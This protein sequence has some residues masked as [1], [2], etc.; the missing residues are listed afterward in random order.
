M[1]TLLAID[2]ETSVN[3]KADWRVWRKGFQVDSVAISWRGPSGSFQSR[4]FDDQTE[5]R[6]LI[7]KL[8][9]AQTPLVVHNL[10]FE[11]AVTQKCFGLPLNFVADTMRLAKLR[12]GG[13]DWRD[14]TF[15]SEEDRLDL[16]LEESHK[17]TGLSLEACA[18]RFLPAEYHNHKQEAHQWLETHAGIK[19]KHGGHLHLLPKDIL[20]R[21]NTADT[22]ITLRLHE[23]LTE[24][25]E[26]V[27]Y[28]W[29]QDWENYT[30][31][32]QWHIDAYLRGLQVDRAGLAQTIIDLEAEIEAVEQSFRAEA[33]EALVAF[34]KARGEPF[35]VGSNKQLKE[36]L[37]D[38]LGIVPTKCTAKGEEAIENGMKP[39]DAC[40]QYPSFASKHLATYGKLGEIL[41]K[42]RKTLLVLQQTCGAYLQSEEDGLGHPDVR[43][44]GTKTNRVS[45][46]YQ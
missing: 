30:A 17:R 42:R 1:G 26:T 34:E 29:G 19:T 2:Y 15:M 20:A 22:E 18:S 36:L 39:E 27:K 41:L 11:S 43:S 5:I 35:N 24:Y 3:G 46:G 16:L 14:F 6:R 37:V 23:V 44:D 45:G 9:A 21:Y 31:R 4:F 40:Q 8:S 32:V 33:G 38:R 12:D 25:F 7:E 10:Q 28:D 13:G